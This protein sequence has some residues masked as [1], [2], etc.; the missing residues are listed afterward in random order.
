[1]LSSSATLLH[2]PPTLIPTLPHL[3]VDQLLEQFSKKPPTDSRLFRGRGYRNIKSQH[4]RSLFN[5]KT[6][7]G[8]ISHSVRR[9]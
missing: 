6:C 5:A 2:T 4:D 7:G 1:M 9:C 3:D 8:G